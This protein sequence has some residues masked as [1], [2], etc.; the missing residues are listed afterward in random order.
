[1]VLHCFLSLSGYAE[2]PIIRLTGSVSPASS[3]FIALCLCANQI[4]STKCSFTYF[5]IWNANECKLWPQRW[6]LL[7]IRREFTIPLLSTSCEDLDIIWAIL[8]NVLFGLVRIFRR[9]IALSIILLYLI[10]ASFLIFESYPSKQIFS[11]EWSLIPRTP[12][13]A[14]K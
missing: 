6:F 8:I 10:A 3:C 11:E 7:T 1:M 14:V 5:I 13:F 12:I 4:L 2:I 9:A